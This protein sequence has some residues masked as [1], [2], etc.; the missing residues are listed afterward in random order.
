MAKN[1]KLTPEQEKEIKI[2]QA[3]NEMMERTKAEAIARG[4]KE[5]TLNLINIAQQ[6]VLAQM[7][8]VDEEAAENTQK[9]NSERN[10]EKTTS[11]IKYLNTDNEE[12]KSVFDILEEN[13]D[14]VTQNKVQEIVDDT[15]PNDVDPSAQYDVIS[16]P[17]NGEGYKNKIARI[18]VAYL[19]ASDENLISSPTLYRDGLI[20]DFLLKNKIMNKNIKIDELYKGDVDAI[21]LFLRVTSYGPEFPIF[22]RDPQTGKQIDTVVDLSK[23]KTKE[24]KLKGDANGYFDYELPVS[25]DKIKFKFLTRKEEKILEK[26]AKI[27]DKGTVA[28][29]IERN[30]EEIKAALKDDTLL[31][32]TEKLEINNYLAKL[33]DW[34]VKIIDSKQPFYNKSITNALELQIVSING[35][36]NKKFVRNY[37]KNM[38]A[39]DSLYLRKYIQENEPGIDFEVTIERPKELGG[40]SFTTFLEWDDAVFLNLPELRI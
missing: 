3:S 14:V 16:L 33:N 4:A 1:K 17:S 36:D 32:S 35:N 23:L 29:L 6:D 31:S 30:S 12:D 27:E 5:E 13:G 19:T 2:L 18:P 34:A 8:K 37:I 20:I 11:T 15:P 25:K 26:I 10:A 24:F 9:A 38:R 21:I 28:T 22:V 7:R 39:M 40:G